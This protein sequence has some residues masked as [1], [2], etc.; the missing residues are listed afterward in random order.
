[1][2]AAYEG[3]HHRRSHPEEGEQGSF[4]LP[5]ILIEKCLFHL[6]GCECDPESQDAEQETPHKADREAYRCWSGNGMTK[7]D[8]DTGLHRDPNEQ[9]AC[10]EKD[11][12]HPLPSRWF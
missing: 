2:P 5:E 6:T 11:G 12:P 3:R 8:L 9:A 4:D 7:K 1:M 10:Q